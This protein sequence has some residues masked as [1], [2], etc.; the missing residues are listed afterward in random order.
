M[1]R[2]LKGSIFSGTL[3]SVALGGL[4]GFALAGAAGAQ[5]LPPIPPGS[6]DCVLFAGMTS[7]VM[8]PANPANVQ[9]G[10]LNTG[11][12]TNA[13]DGFGVKLQDHDLP[14]KEGGSPTPV[15]SD[16][17]YAFAGFIYFDSD[18]EN[19]IPTPTHNINPANLIPVPELGTWQE[20][21]RYWYS[22]GWTINFQNV[23]PLYAFSDTPEPASWWL[24]LVGVGLAGA[25]LRGK[26]RT[27][28]VV[29]SAE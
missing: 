28:R 15:D 20:S 13:P 21:G 12:P 5:A 17:I 29:A 8:E 23:A 7:C 19:F 14:G 16:Y 24:M 10:L 1:T 27:E 3:R 6:S 11:I 4:G 9:D 18:S 26:R 2:W 25:A 22:N